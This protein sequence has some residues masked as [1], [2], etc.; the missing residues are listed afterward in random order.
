MGVLV[1][2]SGRRGGRSAPP[3]DSLN[4]ALSVGDE[5]EAVIENRRRVARAAGFE[6]W[7][8]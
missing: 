4:V 3:F 1:A 5:A 8:L 7:A 6:P 2:F